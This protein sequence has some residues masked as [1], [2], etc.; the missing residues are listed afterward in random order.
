[1]FCLLRVEDH[2]EDSL[3]YCNCPNVND[4]LTCW[5]TDKQIDK[6]LNPAQGNNMAYLDTPTN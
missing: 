4:S 2:F 6:L 1:M 3:I 5:L